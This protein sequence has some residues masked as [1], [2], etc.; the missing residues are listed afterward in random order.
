MHFKKNHKNGCFCVCGGREWIVCN[1]SQKQKCNKYWKKKPE[2]TLLF[3]ASEEG[4]PHFQLVGFFCFVFCTHLALFFLRF[5]LYSV[6]LGK[7]KG[8]QR[9][10]GSL[11]QAVW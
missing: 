10:R 1:M 6:D 9:G 3:L 11:L 7:Q 4:E 8:L 5:R 2:T